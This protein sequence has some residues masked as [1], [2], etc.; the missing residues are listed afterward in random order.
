MS[1]HDYTIDN[2]AAA[3]ARADI[4]LALK[5]LASNNSGATAPTTTFANML[6]YDTTSDLLKIR[7]EA[8]DG[9][10]TIGRL[11]QSSSRFDIPSGANVVS[12][13]GVKEGILTTQAISTWQAGASTE[14]TLVSPAKIKSAVDALGSVSDLI[15]SDMSTTGAGSIL[16]KHFAGGNSTMAIL[17]AISGT[18]NIG[19]GF[20]ATR[21]C[22]ITLK[23]YVYIPTPAG[24]SV[25]VIKNGVAINTYTSGGNKSVDITLSEG[26]SV[27]LEL[28]GGSGTTTSVRD[29][30][31]YANKRSLVIV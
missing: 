5:A 31:V 29:C 14:E 4:N 2:Q 25:K 23:F 17:T 12:T 6:W 30:G 15:P 26:D 20:T 28:Q 3:S 21:S 11:N 24:N 27:A 16:L 22:T 1:Q 8:D 10:I 9:W 13:G 7:N 19:C 18:V